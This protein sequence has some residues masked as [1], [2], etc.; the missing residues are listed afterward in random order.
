MISFA[1]P[2]LPLKLC[3]IY[4]VYNEPRATF[5]TLRFFRR[6]FPDT[7][8]RL[9]SDNGQ[10]FSKIAE[11]FNCD[12]V[13]EAEDAVLHVS[14]C[15]FKSLRHAVLQIH[16]GL[17]AARSFVPPAEWMLILEDD[18]LTRGPIKH[19]PP[20][21][22]SGPCTCEFSAPLV[23][24][25]R[26]KHPHL[27]WIFGYSGCGGTVLHIPSFLDAVDKPDTELL[28]TIEKGNQLDGRVAKYGDALLTYLMLDAGYSN[29]PAWLDQ[30]ETSQGR[31]LPD[32]AF[33]HQFKV[34]YGRPWIEGKSFADLDPHH[35]KVDR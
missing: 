17:D 11:H 15:E 28:A 24:Y 13:H 25:I 26:A 20:A 8:I 30:S 3:A 16:R 31:G 5:E 22:I 34:F 32:A 21:P 1:S 4:Q 18:V 6:H 27:P 23:E 29:G 9:I 35:K 10:N 7:P 2:E 12:Y 33:D 14:P 19:P